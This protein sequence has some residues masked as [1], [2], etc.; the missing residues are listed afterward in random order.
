MLF[1][2]AFRFCTGVNELV[3]SPLAL[4]VS[5]AESEPPDPGH[6]FRLENRFRPRQ[7]AGR[8]C[9]ACGRTSTTVAETDGRAYVDAVRNRRKAFVH[10]LQLEGVLAGGF[11]ALGSML[12]CACASSSEAHVEILVPSSRRG[13]ACEERN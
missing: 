10:L 5:S 12:T 1:T 2:W 13:K 3:T 6:G 8:V 4:D 9:V 7:H 11:H